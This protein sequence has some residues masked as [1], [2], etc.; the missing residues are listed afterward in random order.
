MKKRMDDI[1]NGLIF[2]IVHIVMDLLLHRD[3]GIGSILLGGMI[4]GVVFGLLRSVVRKMIE[5]IWPTTGEN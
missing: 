2:A 4:A 5:R 1:L 3:E